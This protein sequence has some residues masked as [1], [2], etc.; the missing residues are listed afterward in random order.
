MDSGLATSSRPGMTTTGSARQCDFLVGIADAIIVGGSDARAD[1]GGRTRPAEA[2]ALHGMDAGGAQEQMLFRI[3]H[4]FG[5]HPHAE[6]AA[7]TDN[8][9]H[10]RGRVGR[11]LDAAH[12]ARIDLELVERDRRK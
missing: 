8:G 3:L 9:V 2:I 1:V 7:E 10:D 4:A 12:E 11:R 5:S 6:T